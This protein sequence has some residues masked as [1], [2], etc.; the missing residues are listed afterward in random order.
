M[1]V[2]SPPRACLPPSP[3]PA[4]GDRVGRG[5]VSRQPSVRNHGVFLDDSLSFIYL[6]IKWHR[7]SYEAFK[8]L[9]YYSLEFDEAR[10]RVAWCRAAA[11]SSPSRSPHITDV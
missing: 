2:C 10:E 5:V 11:I 8:R 4:V 3:S 9:P 6:E 7:Y 1:Y